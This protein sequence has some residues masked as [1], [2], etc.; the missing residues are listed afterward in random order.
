M[1]GVTFPEYA[2]EVF[3]WAVRLMVRGKL[4]DLSTYQY[5]NAGAATTKTKAARWVLDGVSGEAIEMA[6]YDRYALRPGDIVEG[7]ALVEENDAT[8]YL[9][10][11]ARGTVTESNDIVA[12]IQFRR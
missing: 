12:E 9:P 6:V 2:V 8:I 1:F 3:N 5:A 4:R 7:G 11:F 10:R